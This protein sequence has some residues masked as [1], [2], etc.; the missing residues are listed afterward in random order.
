MA[1]HPKIEWTDASWLWRAKI[2]AKRIGVT[3]ETYIARLSIGEK[4]CS[5][6]RSWHSRYI[7]QRDASRYDG[8]AASCRPLPQPKRPF[9][10]QERRE[11]ANA[12]YRAYYAGEG[13]ATI[14]AT[15]YARKRG[16]EA[17]S[18]R[19]RERL[20]EEFDGRCA[21]CP[22]PATTIDHVVPVSRG[23]RSHRG[24]LLPACVSCNSRK[25]AGDF[26]LFLATAPEPHDRI[27]EELCMEYVL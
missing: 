12:A 10:A 24:N 8:L 1:D 25:N 5:R 11:R 2:A 26:D 18:P 21:Y 6:C 14:R 7:F 9:T 4:W 19:V 13:G 15:K 23:G 3:L 20:I 22:R 17:I 16:T 27:A